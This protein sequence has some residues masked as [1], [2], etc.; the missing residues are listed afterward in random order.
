MI[1]FVDVAQFGSEYIRRTEQPGLPSV[2]D[3]DPGQRPDKMRTLRRLSAGLG[4]RRSCMYFF[5]FWQR[6]PSIYIF[7]IVYIRVSFCSFYRVIWNTLEPSQETIRW[8]R[9]RPLKM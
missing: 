6:Y 1:S 5:R 4:M 8:K 9:N 2:E 7:S 3:H